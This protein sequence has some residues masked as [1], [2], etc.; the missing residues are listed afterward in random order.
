M[1]GKAQTGTL[2]SSGAA[3]A[4]NQCGLMGSTGQALPQICH[5]YASDSKPDFSQSQAHCA[6]LP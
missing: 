3:H 1:T 6:H 2:A 5:Q 4:V